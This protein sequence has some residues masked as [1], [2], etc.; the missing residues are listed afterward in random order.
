M[1][2]PT[3]GGRRKPEPR[4]VGGMSHDD[5]DPLAPGAQPFETV[6]DQCPT[7][8]LML[9]VR[10]DGDRRQGDGRHGSAVARDEHPAEKDVSDQLLIDQR[11]QRDEHGALP[12][13]P[14][15]QIRFR[16]PTE[17]GFDDAPNGV[18]I[19]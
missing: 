3:R 14:I 7:D 6:S 16:R 9:Q 19:T 12:A 5:H 15:D 2:E 11:H 4:V 1:N 13:Q 17:C 10:S 8:T 18:A